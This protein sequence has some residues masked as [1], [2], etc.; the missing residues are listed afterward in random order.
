MGTLGDRRALLASLAIPGAT[1]LAL[2]LLLLW[3][4]NSAESSVANL[5]ALLPVG[6]AFGAGMVASMNPCGFFLLP[7]YI[8][9]HLGTEDPEFYRVSTASRIWKSLLLGGVASQRYPNLHSSA[10]CDD[11]RFSLT[12]LKTERQQWRL[13]H[14]SLSH[15]SGSMGRCADA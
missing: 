4:Q 3:V 1:V 13:A 12:S 14:D 7:A 5:A 10:G 6:Y 9:Y 8:S 11:G 2:L 15:P